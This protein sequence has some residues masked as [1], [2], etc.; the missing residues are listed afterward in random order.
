MHM[1]SL[2]RRA[3]A[4]ALGRE[5]TRQTLQ[6]T[7]AR[8]R[9]FLRYGFERGLIR[10]RLE[11]ID[12]PR[13]Y[14]GELWRADWLEHPTTRSCRGQAAGKSGPVQM[15]AARTASWTSWRRYSMWGTSNT[16]T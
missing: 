16:P 14:R 7:V 13:T 15:L 6:H 12:T 11:R 10:E 4:I 3:V 1:N 2:P 8:L 5:A 9:A